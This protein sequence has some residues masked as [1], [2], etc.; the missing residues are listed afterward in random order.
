M[1]NAATTST[2]KDVQQICH[3]WL[4]ID[5]PFDKVSFVESPNDPLPEPTFIF[6]SGG[7]VHMYWRLDTPAEGIKMI[8]AEELNRKLANYFAADPGPTHM[9]ATL[10]LPGTLNHK[11][12]P[13]VPVSILRHNL[14]AETSIDLMFDWLKR[15]EDPIEAFADRL[16]DHVRQPT[17]WKSVLENLAVEGSANEFGGRNNCVTKLAGWW[18][19]QGIDPATQLRTLTHH[20]CTLSMREMEGIVNR[21]YE[22]EHGHA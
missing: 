12:D 16:L 3:L 9:A 8:E 15:N 2:K 17:D 6:N 22:K 11:Y 4:D 10:R 18:A 20:G 14:Q 19:K 7:G 13:P 5:R 21:M 1:Y